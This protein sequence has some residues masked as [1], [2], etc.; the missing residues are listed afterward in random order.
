MPTRGAKFF[1]CA[2]GSLYLPRFGEGGRHAY[3]WS[4]KNW[5]VN[6]LNSDTDSG[7]M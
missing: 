5:F 3:P 7:E 1:V 4:G 6:R 2:F